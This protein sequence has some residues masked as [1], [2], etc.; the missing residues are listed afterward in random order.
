MFW[1]FLA[2][3]FK[4]PTM[5]WRWKKSCPGGYSAKQQTSKKPIKPMSKPKRIGVML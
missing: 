3:Y 4:D 1:D 2:L 5:K